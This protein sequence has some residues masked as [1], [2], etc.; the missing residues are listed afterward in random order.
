[1]LFVELHSDWVNCKQYPISLQQAPVMFWFCWHKLSPGLLTIF[2][3]NVTWPF[4][5]M[6]FPLTCDNVVTVID[7]SANMFPLNKVDVPKVALEPTMKNTLLIKFNKNNT[8][9]EH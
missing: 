4:N 1:M 3:S 2:E 7:I 6:S 5:A 8:I 9:L